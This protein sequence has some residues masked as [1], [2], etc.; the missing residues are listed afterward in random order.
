MGDGASGDSG[1]GWGGGLH[2][3]KGWVGVHILVLLPKPG[4]LIDFPGDFFSRCTV[5][6]VTSVLRS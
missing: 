1:A 2:L 5:A 6:E 4:G 3:G